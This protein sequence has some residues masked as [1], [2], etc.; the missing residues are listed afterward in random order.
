MKQIRIGIDP[1]AQT[2]FA[3]SVDGKITEIRTSSFWEVIGILEHEETETFVGLQS[4]EVFIEDPDQISP[5][6]PRGVSRKVQDT[7]SQ[8]VGR[9]KRDG[10]L[11]IEF[12]RS[13][14]I[15]VVAVKPST[16]A[17]WTEK[18]LE[19]YTGWTRRTS[20]HGRDAARLIVGR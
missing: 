5:T 18:D 6:F 13:R 8:K 9:C 17:K 12:C 4:L 7:I 19:L 1:G 15:K 2:G 14:G 20:K 16:A 3:K 11:L 10:Q